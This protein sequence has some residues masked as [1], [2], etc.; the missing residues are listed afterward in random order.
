MGA[1]NEVRLSTALDPIPDLPPPC[2][3]ARPRARPT[4]AACKAACKVHLEWVARTHPHPLAEAE[5][6][7]NPKHRPNRAAWLTSAPYTSSQPVPRDWLR[8]IFAQSRLFVPPIWTE[9][10]ENKLAINVHRDQSRRACPAC[11]RRTVGA[12]RRGRLRIT[13]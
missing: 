7:T 3:P 4:P 13:Q 1:P 6:D 10:P 12:C 5:G 11:L 9:L 2:L 8:V